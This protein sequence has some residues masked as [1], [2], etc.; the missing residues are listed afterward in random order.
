[1]QN[2]PDAKKRR[3]ARLSAVQA[4]YQ[5]EVANQKSKLVVNE[6]NDHWFKHDS[7]DGVSEVDEVYFEMVVLG[8]VSEQ[9]KIDAAISGKL[10]KKWSLKRLDVTLRAIMR[11]ATFELIKCAD[12]P[13]IVI[14]DEYVSIAQDFYEGDEGKF[15]NAALDKMAREL[16]PIEFG[17]IST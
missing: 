9:E 3:E 15:V 10:S 12:V 4:L 2:K 13:A 6:F 16:R 11:C 17:L 7:S 14:I 1:M 5:M 8:V